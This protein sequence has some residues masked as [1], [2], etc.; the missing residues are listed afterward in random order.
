MD[1]L[2][3]SGDVCGEIADDVVVAQEA[4]GDRVGNRVLEQVTE[5]LVTTGEIHHPDVAGVRI[6]DG[7]ECR[8][9]QPFVLVPGFP[10]S[11]ECGRDLGVGQYS[12]HDGET[13]GFDRRDGCVDVDGRARGV[14][15]QCQ[16]LSR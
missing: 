10:E 4:R 16:L 12:G 11:F 3:R 13:I 7:L 15:V 9:S 5:H 2:P 6:D 8:Q 14:C 1:P